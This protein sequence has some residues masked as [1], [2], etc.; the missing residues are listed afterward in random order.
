MIDKCFQRQ[1][2]QEIK[3]LIHQ[4]ES[5]DLEE[6]VFTGRNTNQLET[7]LQ[8]INS[9]VKWVKEGSSLNSLQLSVG[10]GANRRLMDDR[11]IGDQKMIENFAQ[12]A[13]YAQEAYC[14]DENNGKYGP[15]FWAYAFQPDKR[16]SNLSI[17]SKQKN[18]KVIVYFR[19]NPIDPENLVFRQNAFASYPGVSG[20][21]VDIELYTKFQNGSPEL[22]ERIE[23]L[24]PVNIDNKCSIFLT[25][26]G[27]GGAFAVFTA[28]KLHDTRLKR[29]SIFTYTYGMPR[30]GSSI[31]ASHII[32]TL[33]QIFR[34]TYSNDNI[35]RLQI[36]SN[37]PLDTFEHPPTEYWISDGSNC[38]CRNTPTPEY[39]L[40]PYYVYE[41][42]PI[43]FGHYENPVGEE[44]LDD[45]IVAP[46][47]NG[48][49][50]GYLMG[51]CPKPIFG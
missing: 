11:V 19:G 18:T 9:M 2:I 37:D 12:F 21:F 34:I 20:S 23:A 10:P 46:S 31:F 50:F 30:F 38:Q 47:H 51:V 17:Q 3:N 42:P 24:V 25:G 22:I 13:F 1:I 41:C 7:T 35:P 6:A 39:P 43:R 44:W 48:P 14:L 15:G 40:N 28:L 5:H 16:Y 4:T 29:C 26:H 45:S 36:A 27:E 32:A 8:F 33:T 49:Y